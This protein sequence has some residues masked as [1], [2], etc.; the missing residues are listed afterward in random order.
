MVQIELKMAIDMNFNVKK[1]IWKKI[2][3]LK[4]EKR[5]D[6][7]RNL[8]YKGRNERGIENQMNRSIR[9]KIIVE[10]QRLKKR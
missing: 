1:G 4:G 9:R 7:E 3:R 2:M 10:T 8:K 5:N 6:Q